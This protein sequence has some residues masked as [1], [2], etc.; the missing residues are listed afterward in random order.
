MILCYGTL[1]IEWQPEYKQ[2]NN[3][4]Q[5]IYTLPN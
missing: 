2:D 1:G 5:N 3:D 4:C